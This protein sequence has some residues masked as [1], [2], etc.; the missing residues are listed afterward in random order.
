MEAA[1]IPD[2]DLPRK[3]TTHAG[4]TA[5]IDCGAGSAAVSFDGTA[6][7]DWVRGTTRM[8]KWA[9]HAE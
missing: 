7:H 8:E 5:E 4:R 6:H 3:L 1:G 2:L 9:H